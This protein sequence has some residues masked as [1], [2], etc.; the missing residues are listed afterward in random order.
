MLWTSHSQIVI[1]IC[2]GKKFLSGLEDLGFGR[3]DARRPCVR[4][5]IRG[6]DTH[7]IIFSALSTHRPPKSRRSFL[8]SWI[9]SEKIMVT[10][11]GSNLEKSRFS[12][13]PWKYHVRPSWSLRPKGDLTT[14]CSKIE[15]SATR[16]SPTEKIKLEIDEIIPNKKK[17]SKSPNSTFCKILRKSRNKSFS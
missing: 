11:C 5:A 1:K 3:T 7:E 10:F 16:G 4:K 2:G 14:K 13:A 6:A 12:R 8:R 15:N 9:N 17:F